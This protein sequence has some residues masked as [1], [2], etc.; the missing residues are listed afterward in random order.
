MSELKFKRLNKITFHLV[1]LGILLF[2][3]YILKGFLLCIICSGIYA[4]ALLPL[5]KKYLECN[6]FG[7]KLRAEIMLKKFLSPR[8][9][10]KDVGC[11]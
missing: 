5:Y 6:D 8:E 9:K 10:F 3:G 11:I 1:L 7:V 2:T 4:I